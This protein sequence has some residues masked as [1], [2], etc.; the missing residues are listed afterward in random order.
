MFSTLGHGLDKFLTQLV[1]FFFGDVEDGDGFVKFLLGLFAVVFEVGG[2]GLHFVGE[3]A[4]GFF[5]F[6]VENF[7]FGVEVDGDEVGGAKE[8]EDGGDDGVEVAVFHK[9][10][11]GRL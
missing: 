7:F 10:V 3:F 1:L 9:W 2:F 5:S 4:G 8:K 11:I 6:M